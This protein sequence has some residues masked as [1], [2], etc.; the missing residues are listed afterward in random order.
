MIVI[1]DTTPLI[2]LMKVNYLNILQSLFGKIRIP[3]AVFRE[4]TCN[5]LFQDEAEQIRECAFIHIVSV[6]DVKSVRLLQYAAGLDLGE[7][8]AI[9]YADGHQADFLLMD[10]AAGRRTAKALG[11]RVMGT[12]GILMNAFDAQILTEA[13]VMDA[14]D[15]MRHSNRRISELLIQDAIHYIQ[16]SS[17]A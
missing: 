10:E 13:D 12:I 8:E 14:L 9:V 5:P 2:S 15:R 7:S 17:Q 6:D 3:E 11:L 4:L 16:R 1:S